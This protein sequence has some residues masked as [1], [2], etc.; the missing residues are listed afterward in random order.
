MRYIGVDLHTNSFTV[1]Y[2]EEG[3]AEKFATYALNDA[4][5]FTKSLQETDQIALEATG[6]SHFFIR[7]IQNRVKKV[8]L[9]ATGQFE[10]IKRS[11]KKTDK[12]DARAI[13]TFLSKDMLPECRVK[14][15]LEIEIQSLVGTRDKLVKLKTCCINKIHGILNRHGIKCKKEELTG[16]KR[17][18][19]VLEHQLCN[20]TMIELEVLVDEIKHLLVNIKKLD[21]AISE[22]SKLL[23][24]YEEITSIKG[25][26]EKSAAVLLSTIGDVNDFE[27]EGKLASY[28]G[29]V[30]RVNNSNETERNGRI[31][32]LGNKLARTTLVQCVLIAKRYSPYLAQFYNRIQARRGSGKAIIATAKKL[33]GIIYNTLKN[34][35]I[36]EDFP[37]F[38]LKKA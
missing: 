38:V 33:L 2:I 34:G 18:N 14:K 9:I 11:V 20:T 6:N 17:L 30:P 19:K 16:I 3:K 37:N 1:C 26:G 21:A 31:T 8:V 32:K 15:E 7:L 36:F 25:I 24:G 4:N 23:K 35:W 28:F 27:D 5:T 29:L 13:A 22:N 12:N 10:V